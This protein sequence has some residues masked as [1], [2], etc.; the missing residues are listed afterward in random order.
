MARSN[1]RARSA[2]TPSRRALPGGILYRSRYGAL[3]RRQQRRGV[4]TA[5]SSSPALAGV[6]AAVMVAGSVLVAV[7]PERAPTHVLADRESSTTGR[8]GRNQPPLQWGRRR[9]LVS[10]P[11]EGAAYEVTFD[12]PGMNGVQARYIGP[13][14]S[15]SSGSRPR[16]RRPIRSS[17][18][19]EVQVPERHRQVRDPERL[20]RLRTGLRSRRRP[21]LP[22]QQI[23]VIVIG[24]GPNT[25]TP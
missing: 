6:G 23:R 18:R 2:I 1:G 14:A 15:T 10:Y 25:T 3:M 11:A 9:V 8:A 5:A 24:R 20:R 12:P 13:T 7:E 16:I 21:V 22:R 19:I 4:V 17:T